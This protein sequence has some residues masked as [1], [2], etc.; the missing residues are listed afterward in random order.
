MVKPSIAV[1]MHKF[2]NG[3]LPSVFDALF[4]KVNLSHSYNTRLSS[5]YSYIIPNVR[6]NYGKFNIR[7]QGNT[8]IINEHIQL[9]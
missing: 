9:F 8:L 7:F 5:K 2:H 3:L 1:F 6:T 4:G